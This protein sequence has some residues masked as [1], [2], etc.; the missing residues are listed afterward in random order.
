MAVATT[1][2]PKK[3]P[4]TP[5]GKEAITPKEPKKEKSATPEELQKTV[6][7]L[8]GE[9]ETLNIKLGQQTT[10]QSQADR[11]RKK[12]E[13]KIRTIKETLR[14]IRSG[15]I[16]IDEM[17]P[18]DESSEEKED[19]YKTRIGI[20]NLIIGSPEY[21]KLLEGNITLREVI[22]NNPL[23]LIGDYLDVED[24]V[25][26]VKDKLDEMVSSSKESQPKDDKKKGKEG[27]GPEFEAP[28]QPSGEPPEPPKEKEKEK[29]STGPEPR[30]DPIEK[31]I[32]DKIKF[33]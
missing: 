25:E 29:P 4:A 6:A 30:I 10:L 32:K 22:K 24:A 11:K 18:E 17:T 13:I 9:V 28:V 14:K 3:E 33:T 20:Q 1:P 2:E 7:T 8:K 21:Q 26:Q 31:S 5:P 16:A 23:A 19:K 15:E 12:A 27:E